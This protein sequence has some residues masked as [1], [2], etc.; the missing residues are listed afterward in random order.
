MVRLG[1]RVGL[2]ALGAFVVL[3]VV[4]V[5]A[6]VN[7]TRPEVSEAPVSATAA[8][9]A[10]TTPWVTTRP[11]PTDHAISAGTEAGG[12]S[13]RRVDPA[14]LT[15]GIV[16]VDADS[17]WRY[18]T[19]S[20]DSGGSTLA[21]TSDGGRTWQPVVAPFDATTRVRV[22]PNGT[23]FAVGGDEG[24]DCRPEIRQSAG[25]AAPW[26]AA[27]GVS[28]AWYRDPRDPAAVGT[29][30]G[31]TAKPCGATA[32]IDLAITDTGAA[33]L[34]TDGRVMT[35]ATGG[36]WKRSATVDG[37]LSVAG[38]ATGSSLVA[39]TGVADCDGVA[40]VSA[41]APERV[42]G[43]AGADLA[44]VADGQVSLS[45]S[46]DAAWL[47]VGEQAFRSGG[48]LSSWTAGQQ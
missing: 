34:C 13:A 12:E 24:D 48:D 28:D 25:A 29:G 33:A 46:G 41:D 37:A 8:G 9:A 39:V 26:G 6:A 5:G 23:A 15:V 30:A 38:P 36:D 18:T 2:V 40:V 42:L 45:T 22:R 19:G 43:C 31:R 35:T 4:L 1:E 17:A 32:V 7:R 47:L 44:S 3:D 20:C 16:A 14:T 27:A 10:V 11:V 21:L